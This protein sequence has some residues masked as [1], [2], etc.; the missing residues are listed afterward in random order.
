MPYTERWSCE[1]HLTIPDRYKIC[2]EL[3]ADGERLV[4][5]YTYGYLYSVEDLEKEL[6]EAIERSNRF[7]ALRL[8]EKPE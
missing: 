7:K 2:Y 3:L 6:H 1:K 8:E 4:S 5:S